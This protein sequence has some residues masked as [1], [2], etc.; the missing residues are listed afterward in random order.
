[1]LLGRSVDHVSLPLLAHQ[2]LADLLYILNVEV[3][4]VAVA[5][6]GVE[7]LVGRSNF[8]PVWA[9]R[10]GIS[11]YAHLLVLFGCCCLVVREA[12]VV[13]TVGVGA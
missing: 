1:M 8:V 2:V 11:L 6:E 10:L 4:Q 5:D 13:V 7:V 9:L 12:A 3:L